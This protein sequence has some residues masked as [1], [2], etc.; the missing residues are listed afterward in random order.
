MLR[1]MSL[2]RIDVVLSLLVL[3][4]IGS[5]IIPAPAHAWNT[6]RYLQV[7]IASGEDS[8]INYDNTDMVV[9]NNNVDWPVAMIFWNSAT[10]TNVQ[11]LY[12]GY[13]FLDGTMYNYSNDGGWGWDSTKGTKGSAPNGVITHLRMYAKNGSSN[14][15]YSGTWGYYVIGTC[16]Y[17][18]T[19]NPWDFGF[20]ELAES[21][22]SQIAVNNGKTVNYNAFNCQNNEPTRVETNGIENHH[23]YNNGYAT[24]V[25]M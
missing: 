25:R 17:D 6:L 4:L 3:I 14:Y 19:P 1:K 18:W 12:F 8:F 22:L 24:M 23:W 21:Q 9:S 10:K 16:H 20:T 7:Y 11:N 2:Y 15:D 5:T 13:A